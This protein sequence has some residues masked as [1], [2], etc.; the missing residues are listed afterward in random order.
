M[1]WSHSQ[2]QRTE[3]QEQVNTYQSVSRQMHVV[4]LI[5]AK[6]NECYTDSATA[7]GI[8]RLIGEKAI[9]N[10]LARAFRIDSFRLITS[11]HAILY[12]EFVRL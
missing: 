2:H 6:G 9:K 12:R 10:G 8:A 3:A 4:T 7:L 11:G 5:D 1:D